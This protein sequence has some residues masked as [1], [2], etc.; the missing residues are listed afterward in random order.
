L[1]KNL[2]VIAGPNGAGK[3]TFAREFLPHF[4]HCDEFVNADLI[5][6]GLSPFAPR[7]VALQAGRL[8]R[9]FGFETTLAGLSYLRWFKRWRAEGYRIHLIFLWL[10]DEDLAVSRVK[11]RVQMG[12]HNIPERVIRR[13]FHRGLKNLLTR[14]KERV[15]TALIYD[16]SGDRPREIAHLEKGI[17]QVVELELFQQ[18]TK[19]KTHA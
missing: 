5:A 14:Y 17:W 4:A 8:L 10:P 18:L 11:F 1:A 3:T 15:D 16:S 2:Y 7:E 12:G 9:D 6:L 13:R 19:G